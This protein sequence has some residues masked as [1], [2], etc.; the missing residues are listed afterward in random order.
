MLLE[1]YCRDGS[2]E[3]SQHV[4]IEEKENLSL[5]YPPYPLLS[6]ALCKGLRRC[7]SHLIL[8]AKKLKTN[9]TIEFMK[10]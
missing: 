8:L 1:P 7:A 4:F 5:N 9:S 6:G 10:I 2:N 3:G